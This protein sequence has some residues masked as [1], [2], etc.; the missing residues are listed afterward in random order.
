[1]KSIIVYFS[2]S[3]NTR[4]LVNNINKEFNFDVA[5]IKPQKPY[6]SDYNTCAYIEAKEEVE[7]RIHP[8]IKNVDVEFDKYDRILLFFPIWWYTFPMVIGT[9]IEQLKGYKGE[10]VVFANSY[11]NDPQY[12]AN[13]LRDLK[14]IGKDIIFKEGLFNQSVKNHIDFINKYIK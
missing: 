8:D 9:F 3:N 5:E 10:I 7:K 11:T 13:S 1:M 6:S 14:D 4:T 2:Y 12:M